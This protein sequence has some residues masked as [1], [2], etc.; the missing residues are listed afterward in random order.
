MG[1]IIQPPPAPPDPPDECRELAL[2]PHIL[3]RFTEVLH[4]CGLTGEDRAA[5]LIFL[6]LISRI[7]ERPISVAV[8]GPALSVWRV[9][10]AA[11]G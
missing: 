5:I 7:F 11:G 10:S 8:K 4:K 6:A 9:S 2:S 3:E 1:T